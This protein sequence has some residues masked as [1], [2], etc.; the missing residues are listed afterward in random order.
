LHYSPSESNI[1]LN[2]DS[3]DNTGKCTALIYLG[4]TPSSTACE[5][6]EKIFADTNNPPLVE[7]AFK[8]YLAGYGISL[9][10]SRPSN[11]IDSYQKRQVLDLQ[12]SHGA[13]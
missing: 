9:L 8:S 12:L 3:F 6:G 10:R 2:D 7:K 5:Q 13:I 11:Y 4:P 1:I